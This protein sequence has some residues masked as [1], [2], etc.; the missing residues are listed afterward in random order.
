[1]SDTADLTWQRDLARFELLSAGRMVTRTEYEASKQASRDKLDQQQ[2]AWDARFA[3]LEAKWDARCSAEIRPLEAK[4]DALNQTNWPLMASMASIFLVIVGGAWVLTGLNIEAK[5]AP[6]SIV[7]EQVRTTQTVNSTRIAKVEQQSSSS[8][9]ADVQSAADRT[10]LN[11]RVSEMEHAM[12]SGVAERRAAQ[13]TM[14]AK[15][16]EIETQFCAADVMRNLTHAQD[17]RTTAVLWRQAF[18]QNPLPTDN[19]YYPHICNRA[20][21]Q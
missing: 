18:P 5:I 13:A 21:T 3:A 17:M 11:S 10:Q 8:M 9:S 12:S 1:M 2:T 19:A 6:I 15:L 20:E 16:V 4:V 14:N 7:L